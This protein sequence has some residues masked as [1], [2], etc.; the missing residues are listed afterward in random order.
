MR[1][2]NMFASHARS[3]ARAVSL[4]LGVACMI[5]GPFAGSDER[6]DEAAVRAVKTPDGT[7]G[8]R[9]YA[10][11]RPPLVPSPLAKLP[12]GA[13]RAAGWLHTQLELE[14]DGFVGRL[15][16]VSR[17]LD[18]EGN[19]WLSPTGEGE[20]SHWE[21]VPYWLK[22]YGDL[23]YL[24]ERPEMI[25]E[26][27]RWIE[28]VIQSQREDGYFGPRRN[29]T[30]IGSPRGLKPDVWPNMVMLNVLQS[31]HEYT[32]DPRVIDLMRRYFRWELALPEED[33]LLPYWQNQR[34]GDNLASVY[35]L[36]N[37][38]GEAWLLELGEKIFRRMARWDQ[39]V[40]NWHGVNMAQCFRAPGIFYQQKGDLALLERAWLNYE[41]MRRQY[42]QV[43]GGLYGADENCRPGYHDPR[44]AAETCAMVEMMLSCEML[45]ALSGDVK[46]ADVCEDVAFNS[47]PASM[48][49]NLNALRYLTAPNLAVSDAKNKSPGVQNGGPMFCMDPYDHRCC[50]HNVSHGWPYFTEHLWMAAA[51]DGLA[52]VL[53]AP[54]TVRAKVGPE[55]REVLIR[56]ETRYP[57]D[58]EILLKLGMES[59]VAFPLY[60]RIPSWCEA[61]LL[62]LN[63][64]DLQAPAVS[65]GWLIVE[66]IWRHG[67]E[68]MLTLPM[69]I[70]LRVWEANHDSVSVDRGPL[71]YSLRIGERYVKYDRTEEWPSWEIYPTT[72]WNYGLVLSDPPESGFEVIRREG[73]ADMQPFTA[74]AAPIMLRTKA[75]KIP[76]WQL[77]QYGL[78]A[79]LQ[80]SP[81]R[82]EEATEDVFLIPMGC[83]R[84]R[85]S[86]FPVIGFG[87]DA[88]RWQVPKA[89]PVEA[90]HCFEND[91]PAAVVDGVVPRSS[92]D[93]GLP[94]FTWWPHKGSWEW[95]TYRLDEPKKVSAVEVYWFDDTGVGQCRVPESCRVQWWDGGDWR[96]VAPNPAVG[97]EKDRFNRLEFDAVETSQ[98]RLYVKLRHG[99]SG[100]ILEWRVE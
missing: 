77:D 86:A 56:E 24:L 42:G 83:A 68:L 14:A 62:R 52:A 40:A 41:D 72:D 82:S 5:A 11:N 20:K 45:A 2:R 84:L 93:Q 36:Y 49:P 48:T 95:I 15:H 66:R 90:S 12:V 22:G 34:A 29:L 51:G 67:D 54:S 35:W 32:G 30:V 17:F 16:E 4:L 94:R 78:V 33:F 27:K 92:G 64:R 39:G 1:C 25:A 65:G 9:H 63:G 8:I 47:F 58:E 75:R 89:P 28:P 3:L 99:F 96:D 37:R 6:S 70:R 44:Q 79:P 71:T 69:S 38:T 43:P 19:A 97:V 76:E 59:P 74:E 53:Y 26:A 21:E 57:F 7:L 81:V 87:P 18:P 61:P 80:P 23:A 91:T 46:W 31:Y 85:I 50:Q 88:V 73:D 60:L 55:G 13:V 10:A 100:G 98:M